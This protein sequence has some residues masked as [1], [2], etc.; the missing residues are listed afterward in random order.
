MGRSTGLHAT[1]SALV[2]RLA[3]D[4]GVAGSHY[5]HTMRSEGPA[6]VSPMSTTIKFLVIVIT[7]WDA[8]DLPDDANANSL[9]KV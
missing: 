9:N 3:M 4:G 1:C 7:A 6:V 5:K 8:Q 2:E